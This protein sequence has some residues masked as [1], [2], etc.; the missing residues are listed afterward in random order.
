MR[1]TTGRR[2]ALTLLCLCLGSAG[3]A[4]AAAPP[5]VDAARDGDM[6]AVYDLG[7]QLEH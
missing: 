6:V 4:D 5:L 2:L 1:M 3:A 7:D